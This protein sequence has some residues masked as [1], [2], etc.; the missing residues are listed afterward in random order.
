MF[1]FKFFVYHYDFIF[2]SAKCK[3]MMLKM[4]LELYESDFMAEV[5]EEKHMESNDLYKAAKQTVQQLEIQKEMIQDALDRIKNNVVDK[6]SEVGS[7]M[8]RCSSCHSASTQQLEEEIA[9]NKSIDRVEKIK[10]K[11]IVNKAPDVDNNL[12]QNSNFNQQTYNENKLSDEHN[13]AENIASAGKEQE[14]LDLRLNCVYIQNFPCTDLSL[15]KAY[16]NVRKLA[17]EMK[18][19]IP[20]NSIIHIEV[21]AKSAYY[22]DYLVYFRDA[23]IKNEF[24]K[25]RLHYKYSRYGS[26]LRILDYSNWGII[27]LKFD[28]YIHLS[29][30]KEKVG[31]VNYMTYIDH[32]DVSSASGCQTVCS[33]RFNN[34]RVKNKFLFNLKHIPETNSLEATD[35]G[36]HSLDCDN[37]NNLSISIVGDNII[38]VAALMGLSLTT[39]NFKRICILNPKVVGAF[40]NEFYISLMVEFSSKHIKNEFLKKKLKLEQIHNKSSYSYEDISSSP[41]EISDIKTDGNVVSIKYNK[42]WPNFC[43]AVS[44]IG[45]AKQLGLSL[46]RYQINRFIAMSKFT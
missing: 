12:N 8:T 36:G 17:D 28:Y 11:N 41:I 31:M 44:F 42:S 16:A 40:C 37:A 14:L 13:N 29:E 34:E 24:L 5:D 23:D 2:S 9:A 22:L 38:G 15:D 35:I 26:Q 30:V 39:D 45:M 10:K 7:D 19:Q 3:P 27:D 33:V 4:H 1:D 20:D 21:T 46:T 43:T 6:T 18:A 25:N 32:I